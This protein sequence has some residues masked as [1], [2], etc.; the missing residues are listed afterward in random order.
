[1]LLSLFEAY[2][3]VLHTTAKAKLN[4]LFIITNNYA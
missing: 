2:F 4:L 1:M 3:I